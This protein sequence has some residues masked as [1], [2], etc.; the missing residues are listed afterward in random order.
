MDVNINNNTEMLI[1]KM[2][3]KTEILFKFLVIGDFGV[4]KI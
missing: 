3:N 1:E 4:G 2:F